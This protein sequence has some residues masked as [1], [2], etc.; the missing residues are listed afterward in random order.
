M[1]VGTKRAAASS[2]VHIASQSMV[3]FPNEQT[4]KKEKKTRPHDMPTRKKKRERS[5]R[6]TQRKDG[7]GACRG[8]GLEK[9]EETDERE[10]C[11]DRGKNKEG[12][13][14]EKGTGTGK[15]PGLTCEVSKRKPPNSSRTRKHRRLHRCEC[16]CY[17][18]IERGRRGSKTRHLHC[19]T[20]LWTR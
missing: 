9:C 6:C 13:E 17:T 14:G 4:Q 18:L 8:R 5:M 16:A 15:R 20:H 7:V 11:C 19:T 12:R 2:F 10:A 1:T 3:M